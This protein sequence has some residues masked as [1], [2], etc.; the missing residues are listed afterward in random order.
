MSS[1]TC[2]VLTSI[3]LYNIV[4]IASPIGHTPLHRGLRA[5]SWTMTIFTQGLY[6]HKNTRSQSGLMSALW[7]LIIVNKIMIIDRLIAVLS[8][9]LTLQ[10]IIHT[11]IHIHM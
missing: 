9:N 6:L 4:Y 11:H 3:W 7:V 5:C 10:S 1:S 2:G 8:F